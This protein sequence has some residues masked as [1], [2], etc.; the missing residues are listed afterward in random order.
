[1][2]VA[3][4]VELW[5]QSA[6]FSERIMHLILFHFFLINMHAFVHRRSKKRISNELAEKLFECFSFAQG[7]AAVAGILV[8]FVEVLAAGSGIPEIKCFLWLG[9]GP[10]ENLLLSNLYRCPKSQVR[11]LRNGIH[12]PKVVSSKTLFCKAVG[13]VFSV[14][15]PRLN[16]LSINRFALY[17]LYVNVGQSDESLMSNVF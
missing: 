11:R 16:H 7:S 13:I 1:M 12:L 15:S 4:F 6:H 3:E 8:C 10:E 2:L 14:R 5:L 9:N 17:E